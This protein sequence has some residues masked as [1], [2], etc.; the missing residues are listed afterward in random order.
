MQ[1]R[2][3][4]PNFNGRGNV[5]W[6]FIDGYNE[7]IR[8]LLKNASNLPAIPGDIT[9]QPV[10]I[11]I[12]DF[13]EV[14]LRRMERFIE[15][16]IEGGMQL[17]LRFDKCGNHP[18]VVPLFKFIPMSVRVSFDDSELNP[19]TAVEIA[20]CF[21]R[22][23]IPYISL[24]FLSFH[25]CGLTDDAMEHMLSC[26]PIIEM[27]DVTNNDVSITWFKTLYYVINQVNGNVPLKR[28]VVGNKNL[29]HVKKLFKLYPT[30][31]IL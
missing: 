10:L 1:N 24:K 16:L 29:K 9:R 17:E 4:R 7:G 26:V 28:L 11:F 5:E 8:H 25:S 27:V 14:D 21:N 6:V 31:E 19:A 23:R 22:E 20:A 18:L 12:K 13:S 2:L 3:Q 30:I 15:I